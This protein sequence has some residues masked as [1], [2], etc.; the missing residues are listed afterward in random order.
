[1]PSNPIAV[2]GLACR[3]PG[4]PDPAA[5]WNLLLRGGEAIGPATA[6]RSSALRDEATSV[7][8]SGYLEKIEAIDA[9]FFGLSQ[10][11]A[12]SSWCADRA[13][14]VLHGCGRSERRPRCDH[15]LFIVD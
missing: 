2:I 11:V 15:Q 4:A 7:P 13:R 8:K 1:M 14:E 12:S 9:A 10:A 6:T 3:F 5:F